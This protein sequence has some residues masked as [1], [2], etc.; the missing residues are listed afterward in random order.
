VDQWLKRAQFQ[1]VCGPSRVKLEPTDQ[2]RSQDTSPNSANTDWA[3]Q[4]PVQVV[5]YLNKGASRI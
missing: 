4:L 5:K 3:T 1:W 2:L